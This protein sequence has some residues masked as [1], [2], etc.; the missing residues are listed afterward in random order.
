[1][2][3]SL[4]ASYHRQR[5]AVLVISLMLLI[6]LTMLG[7]SALDST[8]LETK[9]AANTAE[10]NRA[11][12]MA[13]IGLKI[14]LTY[15][16]AELVKIAA[17]SDTYPMNPSYSQYWKRYYK[18]DSNQKVQL[19]AS[20]SDSSSDYVL[21]VTLLRSTG[22]YED[23]TDLPRCSGK[24]VLH[25][26]IESTGRSRAD[27]NAATV[28]LKGGMALLVPTNK[29]GSGASGEVGKLNDESFGDFLGK[30]GSFL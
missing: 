9:M 10:L 8:K 4:F 6:I 13:E 16:K 7:I 24:C 28:R 1:M 14:P 17:Y 15:P 23:V 19:N 29:G 5:G 26:I 21:R 30:P 22:S 11:L 18:L 20:A 27:A 25:F 2:N 12:Q 3:T